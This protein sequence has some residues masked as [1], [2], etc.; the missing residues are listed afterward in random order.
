M[1]DR[2]Y[3]AGVSAPKSFT[4][5]EK[6]ALIPKLAEGLRAGY[7]TARNPLG[8]YQ[9]IS[10]ESQL[11]GTLLDPE[12]FEPPYEPTDP[13][14]IARSGFLL[15]QDR[16]N[17]LEADEF[18][19]VAGLVYGGAYQFGI[20]SGF[21][22]DE[23]RCLREHEMISAACLVTAHLQRDIARI[24]IAEGF[25][26]SVADI[27]EAVDASF[28]TTAG[29]LT[30]FRN[31]YA[32]AIEAS[33]GVNNYAPGSP[34]RVDAEYVVLDQHSKTIGINVLSELRPSESSLCGGHEVLMADGVSYQRALWN[35][36]SRVCSAISW[37]FPAELAKA[38]L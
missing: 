26:S 30:H 38:G 1:S 31:D 17:G 37:L 5:A 11:C 32:V 15:D 12:S 10:L 20:A 34:I 6:I 35:R 16:E 4:R 29:Y 21:N 23:K 3:I 8:L 7:V 19:A 2:Q 33:L 27:Q 28:E 36:V 25:A 18:T 14:F 22:E 13:D 24:A 9:A